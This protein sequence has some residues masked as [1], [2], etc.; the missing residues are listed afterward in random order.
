MNRSVRR[1]P[2]LV[3]LYGLPLG[4]L[5]N[6]GNPAGPASVPRSRSTVLQGDAQV[7]PNIQ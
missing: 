2:L 7:A 5:T 6:C 3:P 4:P 1:S